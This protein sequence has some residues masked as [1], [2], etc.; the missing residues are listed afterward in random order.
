MSYSEGGVEMDEAVFWIKLAAWVIA[1]IGFWRACR[2][3]TTIRFASRSAAGSDI[4]SELCCLT[5][6]WENMSQGGKQTGAP[7]HSSSHAYA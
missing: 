2:G 1:A 3:L 6:L 4:Q 5:R 7:P